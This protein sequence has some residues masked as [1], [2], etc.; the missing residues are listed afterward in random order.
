MP[1]PKSIFLTFSFFLLFNFSIFPQTEAQKFNRERKYDVQ[2]YKINVKFDR[3][4]KIVFGDTTVTLKPLFN[5]FNSFEL[6]SAGLNFESVRLEND[7]KNLNYKLSGEKIFIELEKIYKPKDSISIRFVYSCKPKKG[8]YFI[9]EKKDGKKIIHSEQIW[10]QGEPDEAH[11][12]FPSYDFPDDKATSELLITA[13][14]DENVIS[15]GELLEKKENGDGTAVFHYKMPLP[16]SVYLISF[17]I[18]KY[19]KISER[20]KNIPLEYFVYPGEE[21][22]VPLVFSDTK[23]MMRI[24]EDVTG[25][26]YPF[27]KYDQTIVDEFTFGGME[28]ITATTYSDKDIFLA[29]FPHLR[30]FAIDLVS[31]ELAHTWFGNLVTCRNWAEL[32]LNE[33]FATYMEAVYRG[34]MY[35]EGAYRAKIQEDANIYLNKDAVNNS[36]HGL[37]NLTANQTDKLF[38]YFFITYNKGSLVLHLLRETVGEEAFWKAIN[39]YL[40]RHKFANVETTDL[41][42]VM[43]EVSRKNL[44]LFFKQWVYSTGHPKLEIKPVY[45]L[46]EKTLRLE[47]SQTQNGDNIPKVFEFPFEIFVQTESG[48]IFEKV[49]IDRKTQIV[50]IK[51]DSKPLTILLDKNVIMP[52]FQAKIEK[53]KSVSF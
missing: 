26:K 35:G 45:N 30:G 3:E 15:N 12:W 9:P 42:N 31:H 36:K 8:V 4:K 20:Y 7:N 33:G 47:I 32:W 14:S 44:D 24:F 46:Q 48:E 51:L 11:H 1:R 23:E 22:I 41:K 37:Y 25:V 17:V 5:D 16:H 2:H 18:G 13:A 29:R 34:K 49:L 50:S 53:I 39:I 6:D 28:N 52:L 43:E 19:S 10:T 38:K 21:S 40:T 27:N